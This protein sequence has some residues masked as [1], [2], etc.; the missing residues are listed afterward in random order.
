MNRANPKD[1]RVAIEVAQTYLKAG[2]LFVAVPVLHA[3]DHKALIMQSA[4]RLEKIA[5]A[6]E[7]Q[8]QRP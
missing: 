2:I 3:A 5:T 4:E 7:A 6:V 1:L 8:E